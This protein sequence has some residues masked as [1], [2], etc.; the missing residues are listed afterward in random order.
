MHGENV[1]E[2]RMLAAEKELMRAAIF[3]LIKQTARRRLAVTSGTPCFLIV[4]F[5]RTRHLIMD[6]ETDVGFVDAHAERVR[7]DDRFQLTVHERFLITLAI[8]RLHA[9]VI[10]RDLEVESFQPLR[11]RLDRLHS[12]SVDDAGAV[13]FVQHADERFVLLTLVRDSL[14][15]EVKI[16]SIDTSSYYAKF[17]EIELLLDVGL[18]FGRRSCS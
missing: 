10:L 11:Q 6:H 14:H 16:G 18:H 8:A 13:V 9:S 7:R 17:S 1:V 5:E 4:G 12:R 15:F 2:L 3:E